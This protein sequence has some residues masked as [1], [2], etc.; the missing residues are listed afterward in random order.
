MLSL[1]D[2][3]ATCS[4][5]PEEVALTIISHALVSVEEESYSKDSNEYPVVRLHKYEVAPTIYGVAVGKSIEVR[6]AFVMRCEFVPMGKDSGPFRDLYFKI[7]P[8]R[9][10]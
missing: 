3:G 4:G 9:N 6:Y 2:Y 10:V 5:M 1:L 8:E 7:L